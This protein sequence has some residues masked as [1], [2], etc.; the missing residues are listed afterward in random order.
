VEIPPRRA[1]GILRRATVGA[2]E[3][4]RRF[5]AERQIAGDRCA[6]DAGQ[7]AETVEQGLDRNDRGRRRS[8]RSR[9]RLSTPNPV[10]DASAAPMPNVVVWPP[11]PF[12]LAANASNP[13]PLGPLR[14]P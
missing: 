14:I 2:V 7:G 3:D 8:R 9:F 6:G 5:A 1:A 12:R 4:R 13:W 11:L 10:V